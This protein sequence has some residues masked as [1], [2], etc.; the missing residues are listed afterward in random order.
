MAT[1]SAGSYPKPI[2]ICAAHG[3]RAATAARA[4]GGIPGSQV[5]RSTAIAPG[6]S[7][8]PEHD[9]IFNG[10]KTI[11]D[12]VFTNFYVGGTDAWSQEDIQSIDNALAA[13]MSD[14]GLN[15]VMVQ[16]F[17]GNPISSTFQPSQVLPGPA[18][19]VFSQ[20][21][22]ENLVTDLHAQG[23]FNGFDL[24]STVFNFM[25]PSGTVL[26]TNTAP[27][28][29]GPGATLRTAQAQPPHVVQ[30]TED[31]TNGLGGYH[32]SV[33][34]PAPGG[35][36]ETVYYSVGVF[37]EV[38]PD[39]TSNGI[40]VFDE[41]WKNVVAT[42]YH[43]LNEARTDA[44]VEDAIMAGNDP[45]GAQFLGWVSQQGEECGD[46]PV[47]EAHPLTLA[48]Q[49]VPLADGSGTVPIQFQYSDAAHGPEGPSDT[50]EPPV[51]TP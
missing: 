3:S 4:R 45:G 17:F 16:Y 21:D 10:G 5:I 41:P 20:G 43:E 44:D 9:L 11:A 33:H 23:Q 22:V 30:D 13:A 39:G 1:S 24:G 35:G 12:L 26:N 27:S 38:L 40:P 51:P 34:L 18:P 36:Q 37:S 46:F 29:S 8:T 49:E 14:Q 50:P 15:N 32:G 7:P 6:F 25:L 42:F 19:T 28:Q 48:F 31:S 2:N 47:F